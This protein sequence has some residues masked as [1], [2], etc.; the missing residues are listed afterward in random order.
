MN[1]IV[2]KQE[3]FDTV[4]S[5][6]VTDQAALDLQAA[7][8]LINLFE[9]NEQGHMM[10]WLYQ[11]GGS[12]GF[13]RLSQKNPHYV[14]RKHETENIDQN[15]AVL[16]TKVRETETAVIV[17][18]ADA[19]VDKELKILAEMVKQNPGQLKHIELV[20]LSPE[21]NNVAQKRIED[22]RKTLDKKI[23]DKITI[24]CTNDAIQDLKDEALKKIQKGNVTVFSMGGTAMNPQGT[25]SG[26]LPDGRIKEF[27]G[28]IARIAGNPDEG[29]K[30]H[31]IMG[32]TKH[33]D[34]LSYTYI[35][36]ED[37]TASSENWMKTGLWYALN[38]VSGIK[39]ANKGGEFP[40]GF[41]QADLMS[42]FEG[43]YHLDKS[44][45]TSK[46]GL[47]VTEDVTI[48]VPYKGSVVTTELK[49][50]TSL[51][52]ANSVHPSTE[53][54]GRLARTLAPNAMHPLLVCN[55][56]DPKSGSVVELFSVQ[57]KIKPAL[58]A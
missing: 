51:V 19:V 42:R 28:H 47:R 30:N 57:P 4:N 39:E 12:E 31:V 11:N 25:I 1:G 40:F 10:R 48:R 9:N 38:R 52:F 43:Y 21:F 46:N 14:L 8:D 23:G 26:G 24:S 33:A 2:G 50:G 29:T 15:A 13:T 32:Y 27:M 3:E 56:H 35:P 22:W 55:H 41:S 6:L 5:E 37:P 34:P 49:A 20:D 53:D 45:R 16:A 7:Q 17:G 44:S 58:A 18:G 36:P 54:V